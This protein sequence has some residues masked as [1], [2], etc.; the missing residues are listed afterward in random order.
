[1]ID[2]AMLGAG[3]QVQRDQNYENARKPEAKMSDVNFDQLMMDTSAE[4]A[5]KR[6]QEKA[7]NGGKEVRIG[8]SKSDVE[9]RE[10]LE[11][12]SGKKQGP[13]KG[14]LDK[15]DFLTLMVT[16]LKHQDPTKPQETNE[17]AT[18]LAQFNSVEQLVHMNKAIGDLVKSQNELRSDRLTQYIGMD[19]QVAS[20]K[21]K[22]KDNG[23]MSDAYFELPVPSGSTSVA[24]KDNNSKVIRYL[25]LGASESGTQKVKWDGI[26]DKGQKAPPGQ[27]TFAVSAATNDG[28]PIQAKTTITSRVN[29]ITSINDGG[30]LDTEAGT[31]EPK[32]IIAIRAPNQNL[33]TVKE[34]TPTSPALK[35]ENSATAAN[36]ERKEP[37]V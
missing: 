3:P 28:K 30:K 26:D 32:N 21:L 11:K 5:V 34:R 16:Q 22:V 1:M 9:F 2:K 19:V 4:I 14:Q 6:E 27:Y 12:I 36:P 37:K 33:E 31:M 35:Q 29:A 7:M 23:S 17:M 20:D 10:Q 8:E 25:T 13:R 24:I 15:D 18:Q